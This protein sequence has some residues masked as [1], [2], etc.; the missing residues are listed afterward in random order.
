MLYD[1]FQDASHVAGQQP[2]TLAYDRTTPMAVQMARRDLMTLELSGLFESDFERAD[3]DAG[4]DL[5]HPYEP[6]KIPVVFVHGLVSSPRAWLQTINEFRNTPELASRYQFWV[7]LYPTGKP[8]P[9]SAARLRD[10]L[11][12]ARDTVDP[13]GNDVAFDRMVLVGHSM[14]GLLSKMMTQDSTLVLWDAAI[15]VPRHE[16]R[17]PPDIQKTHDDVLIYR[18]QPSVSRVVLIATPHRGSPIADSGFGQVVS[19]L[20]RR[21]VQLDAHSRTRVLERPG[22]DLA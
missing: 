16:F 13:D 17:A 11:T 1:P 22:S 8:L 5:L 19:D 7:F 12:E 20:V 14:G 10:S 15:T 4:L 3:V 6:G 2:I 9:T 18:R 21:P